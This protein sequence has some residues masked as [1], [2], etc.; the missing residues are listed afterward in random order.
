MTDAASQQV[1]R[2]AANAR[3]PAHPP[4]HRAWLLRHRARDARLIYE[5]NDGVS[6]AERPRASILLAVE[7]CWQ[8]GPETGRMTAN[9]QAR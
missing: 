8:L 1:A 9:L 7:H 2:L 5:I 6:A 3:G 4:M